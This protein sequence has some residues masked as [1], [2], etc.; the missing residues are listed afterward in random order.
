MMPT[1]TFSISKPFAD[2]CVESGHEKETNYHTDKRE[3]IHT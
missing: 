1:I 2:P 3:V